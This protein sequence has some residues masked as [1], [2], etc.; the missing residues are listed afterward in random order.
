M[1]SWLILEIF[2]SCFRTTAVTGEVYSWGYG[3]LGHGREVSFSRTPR[4]IQEFSSNEGTVTEVFC[5]P[6]TTAVVTGLYRTSNGWIQVLQLNDLASF[7]DSVWF[8]LVVDKIRSWYLLQEVL[9]YL[10]RVQN[11]PFS[12]SLVPLFQ[13]ES[14]CETILM[15]MTLICMKMNCLQ[16]SS[17]YERF[18]I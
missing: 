10:G 15:E 5:G 9:S 6:D 14:N 16:N 11:S 8:V 4:K 2:Y 18:R 3:V 12:S 17:S 7:A 1:T 13:S